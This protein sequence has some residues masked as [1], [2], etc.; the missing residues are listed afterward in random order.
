M[1]KRIFRPK[2]EAVTGWRKLRDKLHNL[3]V[4]FGLL[5]VTPCGLAG[6]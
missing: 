1:L 2:R 6:R 5:V 4:D 3:Y